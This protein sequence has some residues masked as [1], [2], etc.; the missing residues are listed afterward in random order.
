MVMVY[1]YRYVLFE[2]NYTVSIMDNG[3][4]FKGKETEKSQKDS[5]VTVRNTLSL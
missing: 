1:C 2:R 4:N 5:N 3:I